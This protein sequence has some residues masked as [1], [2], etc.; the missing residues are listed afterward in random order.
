M[1]STIGTF[2]RK[3]EE[4]PMKKSHYANKPNFC[5]FHYLQI[6]GIWLNFWLNDNEHPIIPVR[7][8]PKPTKNVTLDPP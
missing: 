4:E 7:N 3:Q 2:F 5:I 1:T 6:V 8:R